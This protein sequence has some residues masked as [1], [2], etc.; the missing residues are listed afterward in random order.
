MRRARL[1]AAVIALTLTLTAAG[2][3]PEEDDG[4]DVNG[5][6]GADPT[7]STT[8]STT[9][10]TSTE[11]EV[12]SGG[13]AQ[14]PYYQVPWQN[15]PRPYV[16]GLRVQTTTPEEIPYLRQIVACKTVDGRNTFLKNTSEAVWVLRNHGAVSGRVDHEQDSMRKQSF[17][18]L[19]TGQ[20]LTPDDSV[21]INLPPSVLEWQIDLPMSAAW[22]GHEVVADDLRA[23]GEGVLIDGL[24]RRGATR[25]A[26]AKC[27]FSVLSTAEG[28]SDADADDLTSAVTAGLG[29]GSTAGTCAAA[30]RRVSA[31]NPST[32]LTLTEDLAKLGQRADQLEKV[33]NGLKNAKRF[34]VV[35]DDLLKFL[36]AVR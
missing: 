21:V 25:S 32:G 4:P 11:T 16:I 23:R 33:A 2:C 9:T 5:G 31:R 27:T 20:L 12:P 34:A 10:R 28:L 29:A 35:V 22:Q 8:T 7:S 14:P 19:F 13:E 15:C 36:V 26:V 30:A 3:G 24:A 6:G 17:R 18:R 1:S